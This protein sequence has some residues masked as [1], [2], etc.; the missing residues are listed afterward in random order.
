MITLFNLFTMKLATIRILYDSNDK[1]IFKFPVDTILDNVI[2]DLWNDIMR[3]MYTFVI[4]DNGTKYFGYRQMKKEEFNE[5]MFKS[6][7][8]KGHMECITNLRCFSERLVIDDCYLESM[9]HYV[10]CFREGPYEDNKQRIKFGVGSSWLNKDHKIIISSD[11]IT[12]TSNYTLF[13][14]L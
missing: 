2:I 3:Y 9:K 1:E 5:N 4:G 14:K 13:V 11:A 12:T 8:L 10:R 6:Y 7:Y